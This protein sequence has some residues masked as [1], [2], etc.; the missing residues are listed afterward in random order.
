MN[1]PI[2]IGTVA[3]KNKNRDIFLKLNSWK[4][5][6]SSNIMGATIIN[7]KGMVIKD[8]EEVTAV[9]ETDKALFPL[10]NLDI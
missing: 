7:I 1:V 9:R 6:A 5:I 8:R 4:I 2:S 10:A 3:I